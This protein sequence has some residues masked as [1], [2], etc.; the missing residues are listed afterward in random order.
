V[1]SVEAETPLVAGDSR[2]LVFE[3][4]RVFGASASVAVPEEAAPGEVSVYVEG[5]QSVV[6]YRLDRAIAVLRAEPDG[7]G[8][9]ERGDAEVCCRLEQAGAFV[10][11]Q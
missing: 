2:R 5:W 9:T 11:V 1:D 10:R 4:C 8:A 7:A 3:L 6:I